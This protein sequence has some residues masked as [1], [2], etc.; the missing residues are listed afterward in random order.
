M[1]DRQLLADATWES[2]SEPPFGVN[3]NLL[4]LIYQIYINN[5]LFSAEAFQLL[6]LIILPAFDVFDY[7]LHPLWRYIFMDFVSND[8]DL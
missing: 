2:A 7:T 5:M 3:E 4:T 1:S 6:Q 8:L